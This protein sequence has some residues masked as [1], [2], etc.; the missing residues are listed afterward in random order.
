M[1]VSVGA[2]RHSNIILLAPAAGSCRQLTCSQWTRGHARRVKTTTRSPVHAARLPICSADLR[3]LIYGDCSE[4]LCVRTVTSTHVYRQAGT[5][6]IIGGVGDMALSSGSVTTLSQISQRAQIRISRHRPDLNLG[7][8]GWPGSVPTSSARSG[9][10]SASWDTTPSTYVTSSSGCPGHTHVLFAR[11]A[12]APGQVEA[13]QA[14]LPRTTVLWTALVGAPLWVHSYRLVQPP[15][16]DDTMPGS[17]RHTDRCPGRLQ[18]PT[19][20]HPVGRHTWT[21]A[22][23]NPPSSS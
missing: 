16:M 11:L 17:S 10:L 19:T 9:R 8:P 13:A 20:P 21:T 15:W 1:G 7:G 22:N 6:T 12:L 5:T 23:L 18:R 4:F 14:F 2:C 3:I